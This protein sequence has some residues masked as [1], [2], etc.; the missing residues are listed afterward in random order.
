MKFYDPT[1]SSIGVCH[2]ETK[3]FTFRCRERVVGLVISR[4]SDLQLQGSLHTRTQH[5]PCTAVITL[6]LGPPLDRM[7]SQ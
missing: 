3:Y 5:S 1:L 2:W 4:L 7:A 6:I